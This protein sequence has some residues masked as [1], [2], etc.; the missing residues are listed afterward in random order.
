MRQTRAERQ[1]DFDPGQLRVLFPAVGGMS[2]G[3]SQARVAMGRGHPRRDLAVLYQTSQAK[4]LVEK[5]E[6]PAETDEDV[7]CS[8]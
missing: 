5:I 8:L 3:S 7:R 1:L 6:E 2:A 4:R